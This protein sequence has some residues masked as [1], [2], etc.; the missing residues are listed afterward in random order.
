M[1]GPRFFQPDSI[2]TEEDKP[3]HALLQ[4]PEP[5]DVTASWPREGLCAIPT[6]PNVE[7]GLGK[8]AEAADLNQW[9]L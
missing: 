2:Y 9:G 5:G 3:V 4:A 7:P 1:Q 8:G 6:F